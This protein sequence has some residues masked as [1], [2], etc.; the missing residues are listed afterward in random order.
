MIIFTTVIGHNWHETQICG[1]HG[2]H[3]DFFSGYYY[4]NRTT[5]RHASTAQEIDITTLQQLAIGARLAP[6]AGAGADQDTESQI[7]TI[8]PGHAARQQARRP[9]ANWKNKH[10]VIDAINE[11]LEELD[12]ITQSITVQGVEHLHANEVILTLGMSHT[13]AAFLKEAVRKREF[14]VCIGGGQGWI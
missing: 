12:N 4:K 10:A 8:K 11:L 3:V 6:V 13:T 7:S 14:Q 2:D 9:A 1:K 5:V